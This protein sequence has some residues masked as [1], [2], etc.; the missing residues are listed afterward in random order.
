MINQRFFFLLFMAPTAAFAQQKTVDTLSAQTLKSVEIK[1][2]QE[3]LQRLRAVEGL[4]IY[5]G[6]KR[7]LPK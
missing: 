3:G 7:F 1:A 4:A 5:E 6:K 2:Q